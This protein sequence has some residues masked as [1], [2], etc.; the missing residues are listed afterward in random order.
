MVL[1]NILTDDMG[2]MPHDPSMSESSDSPAETI[3]VQSQAPKRTADAAG[4]KP[5]MRPGKSVKR[6]ASKA[7][8]C[9]RARKV[10]CNVVEHGAPCTNCRLDEVECVVSESKRKK[11]V[12]SQQKQ[13]YSDTDVSMQEMDY[14]RD[15]RTLATVERQHVQR[16][17][18]GEADASRASI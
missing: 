3:T 16:E 6:R 18:H 1:S 4:L 13:Q 14:Q 17:R 11:S 10:R 12:G 2:S 9:C 5:G 7:C 15:G 8:Q